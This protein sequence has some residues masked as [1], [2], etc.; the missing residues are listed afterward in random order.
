MHTCMGE[1]DQHHF[2]YDI[3][4][5]FQTYITLWDIW[6]M[7]IMHTEYLSTSI[8]RFSQFQ[9]SVM[10]I[11]NNKFTFTANK[12]DV[13]FTSEIISVI[14]LA[15]EVSKLIIDNNYNSIRN[16]NSILTKFKQFL[17]IVFVHIYVYISIILYL[18]ILVSC[19]LCILFQKK[20][21]IYNFTL[22]SLVT[23]PPPPIQIL[24]TKIYVPDLGQICLMFKVT[25][26]CFNNNFYFLGTR[27][28]CW[29]TTGGLYTT[30][31]NSCTR[32]VTIRI[33]Q[34]TDMKGRGQVS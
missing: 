17:I 7:S 10:H 29:I 12:D 20:F 9:N 34:I 28:L 33:A 26:V 1:G 16:S 31:G 14:P 22:I 19:L 18:F 2:I 30:H 25:L 21:N 8:K 5:N 27:R 11:S 6:F 13:I 4:A 23:P 3:R 32:S 15:M 24:E